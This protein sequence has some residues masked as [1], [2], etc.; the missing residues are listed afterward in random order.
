MAMAA[1]FLVLLFLLGAVPSA[2]AASG[3]GSLMDCSSLDRAVERDDGT[4]VASGSTHSCYRG[5]EIDPSGWPLLVGLTADGKI[6]R[7]FGDGGIVRIPGQAGSSLIARPGGGVI[8]L[9]DR[10]VIGYDKAGRV[11]SS[12]GDNGMIQ[13]DEIRSVEASEDGNLY[14]RWNGFHN[15]FSRFS[16]DGVLDRDFGD[17]GVLQLPAGVSHGPVVDS[18]GRIVYD[19]S[20]GYFVHRLLEDGTPDPTFG[21]DHDG[22]ADVSVDIPFY[23]PRGIERVEIGDDDSILVFGHGGSDIYSNYAHVN[24]VDSS[25]TALP[26]LPITTGTSDPSTI[27]LYGNGFAYPVSPGRWDYEW[28]MEIRAQ[29]WADSVKAFFT[30]SRA[31]ASARGL[32]ELSDGSLLAVGYTYG[33]F[34]PTGACRGYQRM[35]LAK[36]TRGGKLDETFGKGGTL[37]IPVHHCSWGDNGTDGDWKACRVR[38]PR[39]RGSAQLTGK[40][41]RPGLLIKATLGAQQASNA[42]GGQGLTVFLPRWLRIHAGKLRRKSTVSVSPRFYFDE[43]IRGRRI[44]VSIPADT[45]PVRPLEYKIRIRP[46][47]LKPIRKARALAGRKFRLNAAFTPFTGSNFSSNT[48]SRNLTFGSRR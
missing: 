44:H 3:M 1:G 17:Q 25:G 39:I 43:K 24:G 6:L 32:T 33:R 20:G 48:A 15:Y 2:A 22:R 37:V 28:P 8:I 36:A 23:F 12:F 5:S 29:A 41:S 4:I 38:P 9:A 34:C 35:A 45:G 14:I 18:Q 11:D 19:E 10:G 31:E 30:R 26:G 13:R 46:G 47:V 27:A 42:G 21:P 7:G 16:F 40:R